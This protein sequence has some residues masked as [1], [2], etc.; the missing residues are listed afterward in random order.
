MKGKNLFLLIYAA[1]LF[2]LFAMTF[3]YELGKTGTFT[4]AL[5]GTWEG[6]K[7]MFI[8]FF[9]LGIAIYGAYSRKKK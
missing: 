1:I 5:G 6:G 2:I 9:C 3:C 8:I 4:D 7:P